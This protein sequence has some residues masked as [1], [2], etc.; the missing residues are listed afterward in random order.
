MA[1]V[2]PSQNQSELRCILSRWQSLAATGKDETAPGKDQAIHVWDLATGTDVFRSGEQSLRG[3]PVRSM[4][5]SPDG[6]ILATTNDYGMMRASGKVDFWEAATG[7][8]IRTFA[9]GKMVSYQSL[10]FSPNGK[11]LATGSGWWGRDSG[12]RLWDVDTGLE[13]EP[14][15]RQVDSAL[16]VIFSPD[17]RYLISTEREGTV[18]FWEVATRQEVK[19]LVG[20]DGPV[21]AAAFS[22]DGKTIA[23]AASDTTIL[24]WRTLDQDRQTG[25]TPR[26]LSAEELGNAWAD[27][28]GQDAAKSFRAIELLVTAPQQSVPFIKQQFSRLLGELRP[29]AKLIADLDDDRFEVREQ[30]TTQLKKLGAIAEPAL[31]AKLA[32]HPSPEVRRRAE[33]IFGDVPSPSKTSGILQAIRAITT[34]EYIGTPE[35]RQLL[36]SIAQMEPKDW[37][38]EEANAS[39]KRLVQGE[40]DLIRSAG[41]GW[42]VFSSAHRGQWRLRARWGIERR[43]RI[44][45]IG[46]ESRGGFSALTRFPCA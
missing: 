31:R 29:I 38:T 17:S 44:R 37:L 1:G 18:R 11:W 15:V 13:L 36:Q 5:Y 7:K 19:H 28:A 45:A 46:L 41:K 6:K 34:L 14:A 9:S 2:C 39:L 35:A 21:M 32:D 25:D 43:S 23:T 42:E 16:S 4:A 20:P 26:V 3:T 33:R 27:L 10:A 30:A 22:P 12:I 24:L 8:H 40:R